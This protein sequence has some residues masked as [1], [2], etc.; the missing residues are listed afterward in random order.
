MKITAQ[1]LL[2]LGIIDGIVPEPAGGAHRDPQAAIKATGE[3]IADALARLSAT[4]ARRRSATTAREIPGDRPQ[5]VKSR[6]GFTGSL[7]T[8]AMAGR[9]AVSLRLKA[10]R[11]KAWRD[12]LSGAR[13]GDRMTRG[14]HGRSVSRCL[15]GVSLALAACQ[16]AA[17]ARRRHAAPVADP[18]GD[19]G[20]CHDKGM[21]KSDPDPHPHLQERIGD[22]GLEARRD[23]QYAL[24][25]TY[26]ICRWSGQLGP[27]S[28]GRPPGAGGLLHVTPAQMNPNSAYYLSFNT[29]YP[30]AYDRAHGRTGATLMVHGA[31][32]SA[33]ASR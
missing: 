6:H 25:K 29:G 2:R 5:A 9:L 1:D 8:A 22:G 19:A 10:N 3:A 24:L 21:A 27:K 13:T 33:A 18:A 11:S 15:A 31:C 20:L 7:T 4:W 16:D 14:P 30:N 32:S 17:A 28:E 26:P 23:G 12:E